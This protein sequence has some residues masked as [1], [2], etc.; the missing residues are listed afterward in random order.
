VATL[1]L[2]F[3][4]FRLTAITLVVAVLSA[5]LSL[6]ALA[7]FRHPFGVN[8]LIGVIGSVG[9]SVN[10]AIIILSALHED[11]AARRGDRGAIAAVTMG[12]GRHIISTTVT[13]V[14]GFLPLIL[15]GGGFWPPFAVAVAGGV[16]LSTVVSFWFTPPVYALVTGLRL[17]LGWR[18]ATA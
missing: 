16:A 8:A 6:L 15:G 13:T 3:G 7:V 9:V 14:G 2:S 12:A 5:G 17:P 1:V 11:P 4:S 10:A 18:A